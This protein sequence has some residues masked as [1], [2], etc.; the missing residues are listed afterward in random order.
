MR[1][2]LAAAALIGLTAACKADDIRGMSLGLG[3]YTDAPVYVTAFEIGTGRHPLV[4]RVVAHSRG[5]FARA[6]NAASLAI[7]QGY[8]IPVN[9][10]WIDDGFLSAS[11]APGAIHDHLGPI[12]AEQV[13]GYMGIPMTA[14]VFEHGRVLDRPWVKLGLSR[15]GMAAMYDKAIETGVPFNAL[16]TSPAH[17]NGE[18]VIPPEIPGQIVQKI[19]TNQALADWER[20]YLIENFAHISANPD[21]TGM[22]GESDRRRRIYWNRPGE[23]I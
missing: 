15:I 18:Y 20:R 7:P 17:E 5:N 1:H 9:A 12:R 23:A 2:A 13:P 19:R 3:E 6:L 11:S 16:P 21:S 8:P 14:Y 4:P 10:I 22:S